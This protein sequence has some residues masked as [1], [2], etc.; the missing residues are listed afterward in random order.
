M[1][2]GGLED[3]QHGQHNGTVYTKSRTQ[4]IMLV[5]GQLTLLAVCFGKNSTF[6][7]DETMSSWQFYFHQEIKFVI[8]TKQIP[9]EEI[10]KTVM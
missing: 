8:F 6:I 10:F 2:T 1:V 3:R 5:G 7:G 4:R 9:A